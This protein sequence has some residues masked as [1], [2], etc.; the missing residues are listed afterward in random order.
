MAKDTYTKQIELLRA[1]AF[2][3]WCELTGVFGSVENHHD[4]WTESAL[5]DKSLF[6]N[7]PDYA[8]CATMADHGSWRSIGTILFGKA[9]RRLPQLLNLED[10]SDF[11]FTKA[12]LQE[13]ARRQRLVRAGG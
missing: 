5:Y 10:G 6:S 8:C 1:G 12:D 2:D 3:E 11:K 9:R 7:L 4:A 13:I